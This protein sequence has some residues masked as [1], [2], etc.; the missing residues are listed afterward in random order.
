MKVTIERSVLLQVLQRI[1]NI[2]EKKPT[3]PILSNALMDAQEDG[4]IQLVATDLELSYRERFHGVVERPGSTTVGARKL[5]E[6]VKEFPPQAVSLELLPNLHLA[7]SAG[8]SYFELPTIPSEDFPLV[9]LFAEGS[10]TD[11]KVAEVRDCL[12]KTFY[13]IP[14]EED[15]FSIAG[16][17]WHMVAPGVHRFVSSDGHRLAYVETVP[18][19]LRGVSLG[20]GIIVPRK[21][22]QEWLRMVETVESFK[23]G[24][25]ENDLVVKTADALLSIRLLDDIFPEYQGIIPGERPFRA[26]I[27]R[28]VLQQALKR[29]AILTDVKWRH[30]NL[31]VRAGVL[32]LKSSNPELGHAE[33]VV[34][35]AYDGEEFSVAFN[36]RYLM[37]VLHSMGS[38][39]VSFEW[40]D[41]EHGAVFTGAEDPGYLALVMPM[42]V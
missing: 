7:I 20:D 8:R 11:V 10:F 42:I 1:Q 30:V 22:V 18:E 23:L 32:E 31:I 16:L 15:P 39:T 29:M 33:D 35:I 36:I 26:H 21:G 9:G 41:N 4:T 2:A 38:V 28:S 27:N 19:S 17:Y 3:L 6:I 12:E 13:V 14:A 37:E 40:V 34:D 24:V 25:Q 5:L